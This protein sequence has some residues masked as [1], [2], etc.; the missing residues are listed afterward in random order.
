METT[1][2]ETA[3]QIKKKKKNSHGD[4]APNEFRR[5]Q[6]EK[7]GKESAFFFLVFS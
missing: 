3:F 5:H 2:R 1:T 4:R 7:T 6:E